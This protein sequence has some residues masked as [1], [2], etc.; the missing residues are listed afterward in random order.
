[1]ILAVRHDAVAVLVISVFSRTAPSKIPSTIIVFVTVEVP[2][3]RS[4]RTRA[5]E[6]QQHRGV[7]S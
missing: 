1:M 5:A 2:T 4:R 6:S 3:L 7:N